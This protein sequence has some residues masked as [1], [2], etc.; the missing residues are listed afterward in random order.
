MLHSSQIE[1]KNNESLQNEQNQV[2]VELQT[3]ANQF[4][5]RAENETHMRVKVNVEMEKIK[6]NIATFKNYYEA[7]KKSMERCIESKNKL[8]TAYRQSVV[9]IEQQI[10]E[11]NTKIKSYMMKNIK[12]KKILSNELEK[13]S[14]SEREYSIM[15][16]QKEEQ[17]STLEE[18]KSKLVDSSKQLEENNK[19]LLQQIQESLSENG[20]LL[21]ELTKCKENYE[22]VVEELQRELESVKHLL[23]VAEQQQS[24]DKKM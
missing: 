22:R 1:I 17:I 16:K 5:Q 2:I 13:R 9:E 3:K 14:K 15:Q 10:K 19:K 11:N 24:K 23:H 18:E 8:E 4:L 7:L 12:I 21:E 20:E 6:K